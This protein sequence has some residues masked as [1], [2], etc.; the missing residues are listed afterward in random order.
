MCGHFEFS[1]KYLIASYIEEQSK[2][3]ENE[4]IIS[5][6]IKNDIDQYLSNPS[7]LYTEDTNMLYLNRANTKSSSY[8]G[9]FVD[10]CKKGGHIFSG[11]IHARKEFPVKDRNFVFVGSPFEHNFGDINKTFGFYV[12][13]PQNNRIKFIENKGIPKHKEIKISQVDDTFDYSCCSGNYIKPVVDTSVS[14]DILSKIINNI[15]AAKPLELFSPEYKVVLQNSKIEAP[16]DSSNSS[17]VQKNKL[18]Y[19][20]DYITTVKN[21][22]LE[23]EGLN[24]ETLYKISSEYYN[25]ASKKLETTDYSGSN[26]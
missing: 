21:E 8:I 3:Y 25:V 17:S 9:S 19:I 7:E 5:D 24:R 10:K 4:S 20:I 14:Y 26:D 16:S 18:G 15:N 11:H 23:K 22:D 6:L 1:S 13:D 2:E 12:F